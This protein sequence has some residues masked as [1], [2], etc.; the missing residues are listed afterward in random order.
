MCWLHWISDPCNPKNPISRHGSIW[1][2]TMPTSS[3]SAAHGSCA[4]DMWLRKQAVISEAHSRASWSFL[5]SV[6]SSYREG[7]LPELVQV[8]T[9]GGNVSL[10]QTSFA[11]TCPCS[12]ALRLILAF[13]VLIY[14]YQ[15]NNVPYSWLFLIPLHTS[16]SVI[17]CHATNYSKLNDIKQWP[18]FF[19]LIILQVRNLEKA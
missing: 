5:M 4:T 15:L 9:K 16:V 19:C 18:Y 6:S 11:N 3:P 10:K 8:Q 2:T 12:N 7:L 17:Y 1:K 13:M 14:T